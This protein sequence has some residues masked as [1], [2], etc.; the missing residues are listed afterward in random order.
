MRIVAGAL[1]ACLSLF[2]I[3]ASATDC[4]E[5]STNSELLRE[6]DRRLQGGSGGGSEGAIATFSCDGSTNLHISL[7]GSSG[8]EKA[9][10]VYIGSTSRCEQLVGQLERTRSRIL[11]TSLI[12]ICDSA[13]YLLRYSLTPAGGLTELSKRYIGSSSRC[14]EE[15]AKLNASI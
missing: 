10:Q 13:T 4:L 14:E 1:I 7:V 11:S 9:A 6:L 15:A 5:Q 3:H 12:G 2:S 8:L